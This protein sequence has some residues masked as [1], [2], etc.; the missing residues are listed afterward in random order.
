M[1]SLICAL[2]LAAT[3]STP[4]WLRDIG[5]CNGWYQKWDDASIAQMKGMP[6]IIGVPADKKVIE[7]AHK[8]GNRVL[9]YVTFYQMPP[10]QT[11]QQ[12]DL[13]EHADWNAVHP[14]GKEGISVFEGTENS[15][16][17]T[18]CPNSPS[19]R[20]YALKH[21]KFIM[22][23]GA[24]G[25]F[26]DN[27]HPD[28]SCE[29]PKFGRHQH[30]YPGKDNIFAYRKLLEDIRAEVKR[31]GKDKIIIVNPGEPNM[32]WVGACDGQMLESYICTWAS[33]SR[34]HSES[35]LVEFAERWGKLADEGNAVI[36]LS[37]IGHTK[38]P[39]R[40]DAYYCYAWARLSGFIW[41]DWFTAKDSASE[42]YKLDLG[43]PKGPMTRGDGY[44]MRAYEKGLVIVSSESRGATITLSAKTHKHVYDVYDKALLKPGQSG[45]YLITLDKGQGRVY[46]FK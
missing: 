10:G 19:F 37:Y 38:N 3:S 15:G 7:K 30:L 27:G 45:D 22:D 28:V 35:R 29:G 31:H 41:A 18:V 9:V 16:W 32:N 13:A 6:L 2:L 5:V 34:W 23:Q 1:K 24:D 4:A 42:I 8:Q 21:T 36:A 11:Y 33:E 43:K 46:L 20:E 12:A 17:K 26:I 40:D 44:Y 14:D 25:L 39:P